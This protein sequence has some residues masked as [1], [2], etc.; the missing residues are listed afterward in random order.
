MGGRGGKG[1]QQ[2]GK[3]GRGGVE[4]QESVALHRLVVVTRASELWKS[5]V[6]A[7]VE[8]PFFFYSACIFLWWH[9]TQYEDLIRQGAQR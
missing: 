9:A 6:A 3:R 7:V 1:K 8:V 2:K 5:F 4:L